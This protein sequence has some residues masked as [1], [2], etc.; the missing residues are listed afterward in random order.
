MISTAEEFKRL[1][2]SD[3]PA[4]YARAATEEAPIEVWNDVL[5]RYPEMASWVAHNKT[6]PAEILTVLACHESAHVRSFVAAKRSLPKELMLQL[7]R[8]QDDAVRMSL[9]RNK[10]VSESALHVLADDR[11]Q[12][13]ANHAKRCL[14]NA[15]MNSD[16]AAAGYPE[17]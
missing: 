14:S 12:E 13:V 4:E 5:I 6:V 7:A 10:R 1:R 16:G 15:A 9:V 3:D 8:D 17:R 11:W 2:E